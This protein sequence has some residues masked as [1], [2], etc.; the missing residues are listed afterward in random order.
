[1]IQKIESSKHTIKEAHADISVLDLKDCVGIGAYIKK[2][3]LKNCDV[4]NINLKQEDISPA[5]C[6]ELQCCP[7]TTVAVERSFSMLRKLLCKDR[8]FSL[9]NVEKYL[10]LYCNKY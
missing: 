10:C 6:A 8:P 9:G 5:L 3:M 4:E 2:R 7:P 1:M